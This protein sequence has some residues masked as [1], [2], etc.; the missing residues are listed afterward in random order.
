LTRTVAQ[1][2]P[3]ARHGIGR[4][5]ITA[6]LIVPLLMGTFAGHV[7]APAPAFADQLSDA[8]A[9]KKALEARIAA[10]KAQIAALNA[11]QASLSGQIDQTKT[12]L[13]GITR[14]LAATRLQVNQ[15]SSDLAAVQ[16]QYNALMASLADLGAQLA[17]IEAQEAAKRVELGQHQTQLAARVRVAYEDQRTS[18]LETLLSGASFTDMLAAMSTQLDAAAQDQQLALQVASDQATLLALHQTVSETRDQTDVLSQQAAVQ[19]QALDRKIAALAA[20]TKRLNALEKA[21]K[22]A[23]AAQKAQYATLSANKAALHAALARASAARSRLQKKINSI[24]ASQANQGNIPSQYNGTLQWP[25]A[26]S[27]TQPFG[28]TGFS[29]E[30]PYGNCAHYHNGIDIV[31][32]YGTP[33]HSAGDGTVVYVGWN[34]ADGADPA[35]IVI[36]AHSTSLVTWYAHMEPTYPVRSGEHVSQGQVIGYEGSTGHSTGAHL[37]WMVEFNGTFV[38]PLLFT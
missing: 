2:F 35:W 13:T 12:Q 30:P 24:I 33:I 8:Q 26:G 1:H 3:R 6:L 7:A 17:T 38:N 32:P 5:A 27:I 14:N 19:K 22:A 25:M 9:Q 31:A 23:L 34:Y 36:I 11:S 29:W 20:A 10:E 28:C 4:R 18:M 37:H 15:L 16:A 21:A